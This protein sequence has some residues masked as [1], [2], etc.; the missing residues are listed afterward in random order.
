MVDDD[1]YMS[2]LEFYS[3]A[4]PDIGFPRLD[5][6]T[7]VEWSPRDADGTRHQLSPLPPPTMS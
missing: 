7:P 2:E 5:S 4:G 1:G 6:L 3:V